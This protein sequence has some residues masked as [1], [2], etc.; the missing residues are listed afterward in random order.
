[1]RVVYLRTSVSVNLIK[2]SPAKGK[3]SIT[4]EDLSWIPDEFSRIS[5]LWEMTCWLAYLLL[6]EV[7]HHPQAFHLDVN[8]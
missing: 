5:P 2:M 3:I 4:A 7:L 8:S 6:L 1:M